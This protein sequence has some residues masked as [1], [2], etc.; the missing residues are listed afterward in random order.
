MVGIRKSW[1]GYRIRK[2]TFQLGAPPQDP[3][4][5]V[6]QRQI[7]AKTLGCRNFPCSSELIF[8]IRFNTSAILLCLPGKMNPLPAAVLM[9]LT[10]T[11]LSI[12]ALHLRSTKTNQVPVAR[13][14]GMKGTNM[15]TIVS[16]QPFILLTSQRLS[17]HLWYSIRQQATSYIQKCDTKCRRQLAAD[18]VILSF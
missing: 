6:S 11:S 1:L 12:V 3:L 9:P 13:P 16:L 10:L 7:Y 5:K 17:G 2:S 8:A 15:A 4:A 18:Q 14:Q